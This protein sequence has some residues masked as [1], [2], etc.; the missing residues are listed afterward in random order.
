MVCGQC[1]AEY[2]GAFFAVAPRYRTHTEEAS[3]VHDASEAQCFFHPGMEAVEVCSVCGRMVCALCDIEQSSGHIC[4]ECINDRRRSDVDGVPRRCCAY[5][6]AA[7]GLLLLNW[8]I[9]VIPACFALVYAVAGLRNRDYCRSP[10]RRISLW[11]AALLA[12][13]SI[14]FVPL[15]VVMALLA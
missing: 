11:L 8:L 7:W 3:S 1:G 10:G 9:P 4:P 2:E 13:P 5:M 15:M 12:L 6:Q 14:L